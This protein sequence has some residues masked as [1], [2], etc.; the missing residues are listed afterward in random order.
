MDTS[1]SPDT[2]GGGVEV[3]RRRFSRE[4]KVDAVRMVSEGGHDLA[5]VARDLG[6]RPDMLRKWKRRLEEDG[7]EA[8]PGSGR[9]RPGD[10]EVRRLRSEL[11]RV[12]EERDILKKAL[13]IVSG[14]HR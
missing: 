1:R 11:R 5:E 3:G 12:Q 2:E 6:I 9:L 7:G 14:R 10:E 4:F 8:F 13:G